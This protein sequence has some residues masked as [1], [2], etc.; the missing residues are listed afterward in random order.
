MALSFAI[1]GSSN[2]IPQ[3]DGQVYLLVGIN[4]MGHHLLPYFDGTY[5]Q[6]LLFLNYNPIA[7][8]GIVIGLCK[9]AYAEDTTP[10]SAPTNVTSSNITDTSMTI[11]WTASTDNVGWLDMNISKW[12][13]SIYCFSF[14]N[15]ILYK[16]EVLTPGVSYSFTVYAIDGNDVSLVSNTYT[17][18]TTGGYYTFTA[19][20]Y[21]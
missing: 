7:A 8:A 19:S 9:T 5:W 21:R 12:F 15:I 16:H 14:R 11:T 2:T 20:K 6:Y 4:G 18:S 17:T 1:N 3:M 10:P 13:F